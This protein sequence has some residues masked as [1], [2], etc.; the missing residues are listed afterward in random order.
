MRCWWRTS[1]AA[2]RVGEPFS[3]V[4]TCAVIETESVTVVPSRAE[5]EPDAMQL[6][7][8][9]VIGGSRNEDLRTADERFFQYQ[10]RLRL[11][12][13]D[14][15]GRDVRLPVLTITYRVRTRTNGEMVEGR[16]LAY[17]LPETSVRVLSLVPGDATDIRDA[18]PDTFADID[19][20]MSR[21]NLLRL[22]GGILVGFGVLAALLA[23]ARAFGATAA[24]STVARSVVSDS[25]ILRGIGRELS[26]LR[27][28]RAEG[29][30]TPELTARLLT[31]LRI[32]SAYALELPARPSAVDDLVITSATDGALTVRVPG[33]G[34]HDA[35]IAGW[36]TPVVIADELTRRQK[37][38][39]SDSR[40]AALLEELRTSLLRLTS[41]Q[42]GRDRAG[43]EAIDDALATGSTA[44]GRV[45]TDN[46]WLARKL[47]PLRVKAARLEHKAWSR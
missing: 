35:T 47:R 39:T 25:A 40:R 41:A 30:W 31:A 2:I 13:P 19:R 24:R 18:S 16:D 5:L 6:P 38:L 42:Y 7:P 20:G 23:V 8:F 32:I 22:V 29:A 9:D 17:V 14:L 21:A 36:V 10:Y 33:L 12:S 34:G 4:L 27:Q 37:L 28:A 44:L 1:V 11:I 45:K 3:L 15:F 46:N 43:D 26:S